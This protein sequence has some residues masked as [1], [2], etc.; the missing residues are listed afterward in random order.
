MANE[1][2][3]CGECVEELLLHAAKD[4]DLEWTPCPDLWEWWPD[5]WEGLRAMSLEGL[6]QYPSNPAGPDMLHLVRSM[7]PPLFSGAP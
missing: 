6:S 1:V 5:G 3:L 2:G 7:L 4:N